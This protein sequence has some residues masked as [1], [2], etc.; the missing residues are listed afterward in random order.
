MLS[1]ASSPEGGTEV[2]LTIPI[3]KEDA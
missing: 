1:V 2:R 3:D